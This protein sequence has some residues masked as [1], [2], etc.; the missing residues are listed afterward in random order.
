[1]FKFIVHIQILSMQKKKS[2]QRNKSNFP[3]VYKYMKTSK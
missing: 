2:V 1:M 3:K